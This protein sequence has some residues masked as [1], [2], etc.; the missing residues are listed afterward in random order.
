M[1]SSIS[2]GQETLVTARIVNQ[3]PGPANKFSVEFYT[4]NVLYQT[5]E[6]V[7]RLE[8]D[9]AVNIQSK[10]I[11]EEGSHK[12]SEKIIDIS[13][14]DEDVSNH[15]YQID[16]QVSGF[17]DSQIP[18][19]FITE[20]YR[21]EVVSDLV[22]VKGTASDNNN[23][24]KV[25]VRIAPNEWQRANGF[26]NWAWAWNTTEDLNGRYTIEARS[27]DGYNYSSTSIS[28]SKPC[29]LATL[30]ECKTTSFRAVPT[31]RSLINASIL[32][33]FCNS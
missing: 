13:P 11:A 28:I 6:S 25:E 26:E 16:V 17:L 31:F 7:N 4:D 23:L 9:G 15:E 27:F 24:E 14:Q 19:V 3:G 8:S 30:E 5:V 12:I 32:S 18:M 1:P 22:V 2:E 21:N 33:N 20:P 10:W 29:I